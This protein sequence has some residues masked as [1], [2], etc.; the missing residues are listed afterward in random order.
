MKIRHEYYNEDGTLDRVE[1][2]EVPDDYFD[3]PV[4]P[5]DK[6]ELLANRASFL[7][8]CITDVASLS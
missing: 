6:V 4:Q 2:D 1:Y 7:A 5:V 3:P 8:E